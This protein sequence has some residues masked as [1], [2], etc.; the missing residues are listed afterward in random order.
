MFGP[1]KYTLSALFSGVLSVVAFICLLSSSAMAAN[2]QLSWDAPTLDSDGGALTDLKDYVIRYGTSPGNYSLMVIP[3]LVTTHTMTN[4][5]PGQTYYFVVVARDTSNNESSYSNSISYTVPADVSDSD[6]DGLTDTEEAA[7][8]SDPN[9]ADSDGDGVDDGQE[10]TDG[11]NPTDSG[12]YIERM[13]QTVCGP[14]NGY[15]NPSFGD[16]WNVFEHV[17]VSNFSRNVTSTLY[18]ISGA[19]VGSIGFSIPAGGEY[20]FAVHDASG[21]LNDSYGRVCS[22]SDGAE[23]DVQGRVV[24]YKPGESN[25]AFDGTYDFAFPVDLTSGRK[26]VQ[27]A[28]FNTFYASYYAPDQFP[29]PNVVFNY[30]DM[31]N[32]GNTTLNGEL[33]L[34]DINGSEINRSNVSLAPQATQGFDGGHASVGLNQMGMVKFVPDSGNVN[35]PAILSLSRYAYNNKTGFPADFTTAT[36][37]PGLVG[38]K[39]LQSAPIDTRTVSSGGTMSSILELLNPNSSISSARVRVYTSTGSL[40]SDQ[41]LAIAPNASHH[42]QTENLLGAEQIGTVTVQSTNAVSIAALIMQYARNSAGQLEFN[43]SVPLRVAFGPVVRTSYNTYLGHRGSVLIVNP[44]N[45]I[46]QASLNIT[47]S[48]GTM[49]LAG[50]TIDIPA[51]G[52]HEAIINNYEAANQYGV[53]TV[54]GQ[55]TG[56]VTRRQSNF[57]LIPTALKE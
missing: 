4:L 48:D 7:I 1:R 38:T 30:A 10:V 26:G 20:D 36:A 22:T 24:Y 18:S 57:Y 31:T 8:G 43:Y 53:V 55:F 39:D 17:N 49:L 28:P 12:S 27:V 35:D 37:V 33:I 16:K 9:L 44:T 15:L 11:S 47:R 21:F 56:Y 54:Q 3:G 19:N 46:Q 45:S 6:G 5:S 51:Y 29:T 41:T 52:V 50:Q 2:L 40:V 42:I 34:Y 14:W 23:G 25:G 13:G 32:P